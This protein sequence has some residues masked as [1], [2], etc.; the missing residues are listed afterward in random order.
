ME[1]KGDKRDACRDLVGEP[2]GKGPL[3]RVRQKLE[4]NIKT[5]LEEI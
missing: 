1:Y 4:A 3:G 5:N 2:D